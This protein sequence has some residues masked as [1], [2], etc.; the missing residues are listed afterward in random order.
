MRNLLALIGL[1]VVLVGGLGWYLG[2][3]QLA[4]QP[5]VDGHRTITV[6]VN[7]KKAVEDGKNGVQKVS[8]IISSETKGNPGTPPDAKQVEGQPTGFQFNPDGSAS[9]VLPKI[10]VKTGN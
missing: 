9:F 6:D 2:W 10:E 1:A 3:Y 4:T 5:G 8:N 7:T